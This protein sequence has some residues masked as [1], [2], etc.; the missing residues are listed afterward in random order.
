MQVFHVCHA[1]RH[2]WLLPSYTTLSDFDLGLQ[3]QGQCKAKPLDF[4]FST[5]Q[6]KI[7]YDIE[8]I[9]VEY[10]DFAFQW[11]LFRERE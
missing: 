7:W 4:L 11:E 5:N 9:Q 2:H 3:S 6:D 10:L 8:A 1:Y